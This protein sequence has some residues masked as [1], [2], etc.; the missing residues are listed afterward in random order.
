MKIFS[1]PERN[2]LED[3]FFS[4]YRNKYYKKNIPIVIDNGSHNCRVGWGD[5]TTARM[6]FRPQ[7]ARVRAKKE[8]EPPTILVGNDIRES[9]ISKLNTRTQFDQNIVYHF[10][11]Q[12][13]ILD[14][15]FQRL[16]VDSPAVASPVLMTEAICNPSHCRS[17]M[18]ELLFECYGVPAVCYGIDAI[19][20]LY[21]NKVKSTVS[22]SS[23]N[24]HPPPT[25]FSA[26]NYLVISSSN[27]ATHIFPVVNGQ[28][29]PNKC[30]RLG[31]GG[32]AAS[33][34]LRKLLHLKYPIHRNVVTAVRAQYLKEDHAYVAE[35]YTE[36]LYKY[37]NDP[38]F[39]EAHRVVIRLPFTPQNP[40]PSKAD[41]E[42]KT[43][44]RKEQGQRLKEVN[45]KKQ[46]EKRAEREERLACLLEIKGMQSTNTDDFLEALEAEGLSG[47]EE[48]NAN[49]TK[50]EEALGK[51]LS[52]PQLP[53]DQLYPLLEV[54]DSQLN[55]DQLK[56]KQRQRFVKNMRD[57]RLAAKKKKDETKQ[58]ED[59]KF[60]QNPQQYLA[61]LHS[62]RQALLA[63]R[64]QRQ[65]QPVA[66]AGRRSRGRSNVKTLAL[67]DSEEPKKSGKR[68]IED[69]FGEKDED[70][71]VYLD[72]QEV[73]K[74]ED[75]AQI[76]QIE[77]L[78]ATY[79][80]DFAPTGG[81]GGQPAGVIDEQAMYE[82]HLGVERIRVSETVF[83]PQAIL[84]IEQM[85]IV[86]IIQSILSTFDEKTQREMA[87]NIFYTGGN[88]C[89]EGFDTRLKSEVQAIRPFESKFHVSGAKDL[90]HDSWW[91]MAKW[92][93]TNPDE[94]KKS[95]VTK[96]EYEERGGDYIKPFFASN[97]PYL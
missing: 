31:V 95:V 86:E 63:R 33:E 12:E 40:Q 91:G 76:A 29:I 25:S 65:K 30:K 69:T 56:E 17:A 47:E 18:S 89:Y 44:I 4:D 51:P 96:A 61:D 79:D 52:I 46:K 66:S 6:L 14:H 88:T 58:V 97:L 1:L 38:E 59:E 53:D 5:E 10:E 24:I 19:F 68:K 87:M 78:L 70:W 73:Q 8:S 50:L 34:Y 2:N 48:L 22:P 72:D 77:S 75:D 60:N 55:E 26:S 16:G 21:A 81:D 74:E 93:Q 90:I 42:R 27:S 39:A 67:R 3:S 36:E 37:Q 57:G 82:L 28:W 35:N 45:E 83:E 85:G 49:I 92:Y 11:T 41:Q 80:P 13:A 7:V 15:V 54:P 43:Q 64:E 32:A 84:G 9:E 71:D 62:K 94:F 20:S 23:S